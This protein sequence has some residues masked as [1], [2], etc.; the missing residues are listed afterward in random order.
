MSALTDISTI[1]GSR[2]EQSSAFRNDLSVTP[3]ELVLTLPGVS[4]M[5]ARSSISQAGMPRLTW[6]RGLQSYII[7]TIS[8]PPQFHHQD[9]SQHHRPLFVPGSCYFRT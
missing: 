2:G 8:L 3:P 5:A 6:S 4:V 1:G 7:M 9:L